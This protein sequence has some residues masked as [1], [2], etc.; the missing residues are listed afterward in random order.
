MIATC[1]HTFEEA[2]D[3]RGC[4]RP[5]HKAEDLYRC[6]DCGNPFH[7][8]CAIRHFGEYSGHDK[9]LAEANRDVDRALALVDTRREQ[10]VALEG[11]VG[12]LRARVAEL[13][14]ENAML[15]DSIGA[16]AGGC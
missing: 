13:E 4:G 9:A 5:I 12:R 16:T 11:E 14:A 15:A 7:R 1:G 8:D 3:L 10:I 2:P 6:T